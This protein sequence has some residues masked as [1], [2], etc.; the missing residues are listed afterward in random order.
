[1]N[2]KSDL[3]FLY[4]LLAQVLI[5]IR[6]DCYQDKP[7]SHILSHLFH[8]LPTKL[9]MLSRNEVSEHE[10]ISDF[11]MIFKDSKYKKWILNNGS[12]FKNTSI[13]QQLKND[14]WVVHKRYEEEE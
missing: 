1:M 11:I 2:N 14:V 10:M 9:G 3:E 5:E 12:Q 6:E 8:N 4:Y 13:V 7:K